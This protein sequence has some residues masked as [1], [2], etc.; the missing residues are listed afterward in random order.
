MLVCGS[1]G[2]NVKERLQILCRS[3]DGYE[4]AQRDLELRGPGSFFGEAQH[5]LPSLRMASLTAD[6]PLLQEA[7]RAAHALLET[8]PALSEP[9]HAALRSRV[10][11]LFDTEDGNTFN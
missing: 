8:D 1:G 4:I 2:K 11:A 7:Q 9:E 3:N 5:G 6:M 10:Y